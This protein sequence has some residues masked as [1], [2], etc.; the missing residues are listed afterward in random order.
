MGQPSSAVDFSLIIPTF[1]EGDNLPEL[2]ARIDCILARRAFEVLLVDDDSPDGTWAAAKK[3]QGQYQ[4]L[5]V[6]RRTAERG[7]S[8]AVVCGFREARG[9]VLGV[10]DGDLQHDESR[11]PEL[12]QEMENADFA[13]ATRQPADGSAGRWTWSRR[14]TSWVATML[15][16][17]IAQVPL[18]DPMSGYFAIRRELFMALDDSTMRPQGYKILLYLYSRAVQQF[19]AERLRLREIG[20]QFRKRTHGKSKL[21][22]RV[23]VEYVLMLIELR[24][25]VRAKTPSPHFVPAIP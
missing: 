4:W 20:Y 7:L 15:A 25:R 16:R 19:G 18:S 2:F 3:L 5:R 23:I 21:T 12:L 11:L 9:A 8:S 1:N 24:I 6:I 14:F 17:A 10:M 13:I 22:S